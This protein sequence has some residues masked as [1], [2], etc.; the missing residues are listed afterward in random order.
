MEKIPGLEQSLVGFPEQFQDSFPFA[1]SF[2][3]FGFV[4][5]NSFPSSPSYLSKEMGLLR[6]SMGGRQELLALHPEAA[7]GILL[8]NGIEE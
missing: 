4:H 1:P 6:K 5:F 8:F 2:L 7:G 3:P